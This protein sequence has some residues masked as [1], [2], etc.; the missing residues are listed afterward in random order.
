LKPW[1]AD[2]AEAVHQRRQRTVP[3]P[4]ELHGLAIAQQARAAAHRA[5][6][7]FGFES[8]KL[9]GCRAFDILAP[10]HRLEFRGADLAAE[11][12]HF[13]IGNRNEFAVPFFGQLDTELAFQQVGYTALA[14][15]AVDPDHLA[16][17]AANVSRVDR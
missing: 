15:L 14:R 12:V 5:V 9:P 2:V 11:P 4:G 6:A 8:A 1:H 16:V 13:V 10:K 17:F 3:F 7:A